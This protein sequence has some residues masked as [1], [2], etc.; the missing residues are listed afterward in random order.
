MTALFHSPRTITYYF[1]RK[2]T[3]KPQEKSQWEIALEKKLERDRLNRMDNINFD[4]APDERMDS[5]FDY[6]N[7]N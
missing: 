6:D 2:F 3:P 5:D 4:S 7:F 1:N